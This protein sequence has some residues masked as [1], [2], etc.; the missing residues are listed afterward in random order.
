MNSLLVLR[1][2]QDPGRPGAESDEADHAERKD[3]GVADE[4]VER[5]DDRD[6]DERVEEVRLEV[7]RDRK[8]E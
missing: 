3:A 1:H 2:R 6:L 5:D 4:D 7:A 8:A